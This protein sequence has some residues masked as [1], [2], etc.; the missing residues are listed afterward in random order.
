MQVHIIQHLC[1]IFYTFVVKYVAFWE[2]VLEHLSLDFVYVCMNQ[3]EPN[4]PILLSL[5]LFLTKSI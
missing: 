3:I 4:C 2:A 1:A 5:V